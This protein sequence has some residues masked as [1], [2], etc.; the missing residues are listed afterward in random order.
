VLAMAVMYVTR[1]AFASRYASTILPL[2]LLLVAG[3]L[4]RLRDLR[5]L[6]GVLA[7]VL[8]LSALG[9]AFNVRTDRTQAGDVA[10]HV[11]ARALPGDLV[12]YCPD[13]VAPAALRLMRPG[14]EHLTFPHQPGDPW[15]ADRVDWVDYAARNAI[16][17][18][19]YARTIA[20]YTAGRGLFVMFSGAYKTHKGT[21]EELIDELAVV[22]GNPETLAIA[23]GGTYYESAGLVYFGPGGR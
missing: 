4:S 14:L 3:G 21:C 6:G 5:V 2:V 19:A 8:A 7:L 10:S 20:R 9:A 23:D 1:S 11:A 15:P 16:D 13:Q 17:P 12:L 22:R 18:R